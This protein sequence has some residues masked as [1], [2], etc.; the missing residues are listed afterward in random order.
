MLF[1]CCVEHPD[2]LSEILAKFEAERPVRARRSHRESELTGSERTLLARA[3]S[4]MG[5]CHVR[6]GVALDNQFN[7]QLTE[8]CFAHSIRLSKLAGD[9]LAASPAQNGYGA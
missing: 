5:W 4:Q 3:L 9:R 7:V 1:M 2:H 8:S 6:A